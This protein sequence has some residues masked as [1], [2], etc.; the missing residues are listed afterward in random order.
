MVRLELQ[1]GRDEAL[2]IL[3]KLAV[4]EEAGNLYYVHSKRI[5]KT[6]RS[7][8]EAEGIYV[9]QKG[10]GYTYVCHEDNREMAVAQMP[11]RPPA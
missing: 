9:Y 11:L 10:K 3:D 7:F 1:L 6:V 2:Y 5:N 8:L 4:C